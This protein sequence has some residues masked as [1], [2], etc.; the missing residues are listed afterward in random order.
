[1]MTTDGPHVIAHML[2]SADTGPS[3]H[4]SCLPA[5][6]MSL[7]SP[8]DTHSELAESVELELDLERH[9]S[10]SA[11]S[12]RSECLSDAEI[13]TE[14]PLAAQSTGQNV[15]TS[16]N[17]HEQ[18]TAIHTCSMTCIRILTLQSQDLPKQSMRY[19]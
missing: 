3:Q 1:M 2:Q 6:E 15:H 14:P 13:N 4:D 16:G 5:K 10:S 8:S 7:Q 11:S 9:D 19:A 17:V 18:H 12:F